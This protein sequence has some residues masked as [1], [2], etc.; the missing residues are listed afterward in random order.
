MVSATPRPPYP[1]ERDPVSIVQK[2][3]WTSRPVWMGSK[4]LAATGV[5]PARW[6]VA[7]PAVQ[8]FSTFCQLVGKCLLTENRSLCSSGMLR[9]VRRQ[10]VNDVL[11]Q[12][13][14][15]LKFQAVQ[16]KK[17]YCTD[18]IACSSSF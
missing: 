11:A 14:P 4:N 7:I 18:K 9:G 15:I 13:I 2:A 3:E 17:K 10:F 5:R 16:K 12:I 6:R 1:R 8:Q